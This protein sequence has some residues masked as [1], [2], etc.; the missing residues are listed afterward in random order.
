[1]QETQ[2]QSLGWK[3]PLQKG[4]QT[5]PVFLPVEFRGQGSLADYSPWG[6]KGSDTTGQI[7]YPLSLVLQA[8][9]WM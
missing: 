4:M 2:V 1:M 8:E 7:S 9:V 3:D 5:T 6:H